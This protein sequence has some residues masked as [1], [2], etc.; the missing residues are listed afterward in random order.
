MCCFDVNVVNK[1]FYAIL[2]LQVAQ[3][4]P[5]VFLQ[6]PNTMSA[7]IQDLALIVNTV[8]LI[9]FIVIAE[10]GFT[11]IPLEKRKRLRYI[12]P[13]IVVLVGLLL[14]AARLQG[15]KA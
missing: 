7:N 2:Q 1:N 3:E 12:Y 10:L 5:T 15:G 13:L 4:R 8:L 6:L 14:I 11:E 9:V